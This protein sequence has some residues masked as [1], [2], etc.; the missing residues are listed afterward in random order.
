MSI[1]LKA[2][3]QL[4]LDGQVYPAGQWVSLPDGQ[5]ERAA[6]LLAYGLAEEA[7]ADPVKKTR[8]RAPSPS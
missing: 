2:L 3:V 5:E 6:E 8:K 7:P 1:P 4:E